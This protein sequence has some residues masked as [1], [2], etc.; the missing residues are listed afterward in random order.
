M[1]GLACTGL[2]KRFPG[3]LA[4]DQVDLSVD[5][6][7]VVVLLGE[8]GAGKS[9]LVKC[10]SGVHQPDEG[11]M[12]FDG[13]PWAPD[14]PGDAID[15]GIG[16]I[17]QEMTLLGQLSVAE[18][19][20]LGRLPVARGRLDRAGMDEASHEV[21]ARVG[22]DLDPA[23]LVTRLSVAQQQLV[24]IAK[25]LS[26]DARL[27]ILDEPTAALGG[28]DT[29]RLFGIVDD[30]RDQGVGFIHISHRLEEVARIGD[31][32]VVLRDGQRVAHFDD[33]TVPADEFVRAMVGRDVDEQMDAPAEH[34]SEV[35]LSVRELGRDGVFEG[36][37]FDLHRGEVLGVAGL[38]GAGRTDVARA[39]FGAEP[40]TAGTMKLDGRLYAP[41]RPDDA[42]RAGIVLVPED[43][44]TQGVVLDLSV[45]DNLA[46]PSLR[47]LGPVVTARELKALA[48]V[49]IDRLAIRG[50]AAQ[51]A[52]TLSGGNQQKVVIGKWLH[53]QP[54]VIIFDEPTR[55][56]DVGA[57]RSIHDLV[58]D[59]AARGSAVLII[60]SD[61]PEV[62]GLSHR[63]L[64][65]ADG[66]HTATLER[67]DAT[68][69]AVMS[70]A[71]PQQASQAPSE[72]PPKD[73]P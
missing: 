73:A 56:I 21:L 30:L 54:R 27:L 61:L 53:R 44:K 25:A 2:V 14:T 26:L 67:A 66:H 22:L 39:L 5:F 45:A 43:R 24:E 51:S 47:S 20:H 55:G 9:T 68:E 70:H 52:G 64:V 71:V 1:S 18:N 12:A 8:N 57:K 4:L 38:V 19:I 37:S 11:I 35:V 10:I 65:M 69:E 32:V 31:R 17:H 58:H 13:Q 48:D 72:D 63:V 34:A 50:R 23:T 41:A 42:V 29:A 7:E 33:P 46:L 62:L 28:Q 3:T 6:G 59:L 49:E 60:S 40:P 36:V 15:G 16:M